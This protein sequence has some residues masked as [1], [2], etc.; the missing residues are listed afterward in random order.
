MRLQIEWQEGMM[1]LR[2]HK[3]ASASLTSPKQAPKV[4][5]ECPVMATSQAPRDYVLGREQDPDRP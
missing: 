2:P 4:C 5:R 3:R 1:S